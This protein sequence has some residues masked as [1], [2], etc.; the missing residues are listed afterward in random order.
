MCRERMPE[1]ETRRL[2]DVVEEDN[3]E[4]WQRRDSGRWASPFTVKVKKLRSPIHF[5]WCFENVFKCRF[6]CKTFSCN[7]VRSVVQITT[8]VSDHGSCAFSE[9]WKPTT[10]VSPHSLQQLVPELRHPV[11]EPLLPQVALCHRGRRCAPGAKTVA[12]LFSHRAGA[13][14][15]VQSVPAPVIF[16]KYVRF[17]PVCPQ[18]LCV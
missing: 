4:V 11:T 15:L 3:A 13:P 6:W 12:S 14:V 5:V 16:T 18:L 9:L 2:M 1:E 17:L 10:P 8:D 7:S